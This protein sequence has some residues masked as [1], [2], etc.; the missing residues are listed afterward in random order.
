MAKIGRKRNIDHF[1]ILRLISIFNSYTNMD[2][3]RLLAILFMVFFLSCSG[4]KDQDR[5]KITTEK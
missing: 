1:R 4:D 2:T 3:E 5:L